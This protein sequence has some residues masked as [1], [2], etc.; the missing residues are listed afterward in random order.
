VPKDRPGKG[1]LNWLIRRLRYANP[2]LGGALTAMVFL[3]FALLLPERTGQWSASAILLMAVLISSSLWGL[4]QGLI[5]SFIAAV[6][7]DFFFIPPLYSLRIDDWPHAVSL[8]LLGLTA[9]TISIF[10]EAFTQSGRA[11]RRHQII[12]RRVYTLGR[13]LGEAND[14][15]EIA[16]MLVNGV[17]T[18]LGA[19]AVLF[20]LKANGLVVGA[21][22]PRG[23]SLTP[24]EWE[25]ALNVLKAKRGTIHDTAG[26]RADCTA[27]LI[28]DAESTVVLAIGQT[29]RRLW[30]LPER[31]HVIETL[32]GGAAAAFKRVA[33]HERA[34]EAR[35]AA[36][37][38]RLRSAFLTSLSHELKTP[39]AV[40]LGS[41]SSL[42]DLKANLS[43]GAAEELLR[44]ILD[45]G[46]H[47]NRQIANLLDMTCV[48]SNGLRPERHPSDLGDIIGSVLDRAK[49]ALTYHY[50]AV[51]IPDD[52][53]D[54]DVDPI[55][56]EKA[57]FNILENAAKYTPPGAT[58]ALSA[59]LRHGSVILTICDEG[60]GIQ[61]KDMPHLFEKFYR[62]GDGKRKPWGT[63]LGLAIARA[64]LE[65]MG[66]TITASNRRDRSGALF[67]IELRPSESR[68]RCKEALG[69]T[70]HARSS[71]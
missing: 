9:V 69:N 20:E 36:E 57:I 40:I 43:I 21:A 44:S 70:S 26:G 27:V 53:P 56:M 61:P 2:Y 11:G 33:L 49:R 65:A 35:L 23:A 54:I 8:A 37:A 6:A 4:R 51:E 15:A 18:V 10:A 41:A 48:E 31:V 38:E 58:I 29:R 7:Y 28:G 17:G 62:G 25:T 34:E 30:Q 59:S 24:R 14:R 3:G 68:A 32:A 47:L 19:T 12:A 55:L 42:M 46:E 63:G 5:S 22:H 66:A 1:R 60:S 39:L 52:I 67:A 16:K 13:Y 50:V 45:E 71:L 64:F